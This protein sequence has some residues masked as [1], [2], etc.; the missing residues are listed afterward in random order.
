MTKLQI[1]HVIV[2]ELI[3]ES[4]KDFDHSKPYN[5]RESELDKA[6]S[7]VIQLVNGVVELYGTKGNAAHYG[8]FKSNPMEQGPVPNLFHSYQEIK[9]SLSADFINL[10]K[11]VMKQM[12]KSAQKQTWSS[13]GYVVF[14]D[15]IISNLRYLL[16]T[17][18]KKTNGVTISDNLEPEEMIHLELNNINQAAKINFNFYFSYQQ[19]DDLKKAELSYLSFISKTTGQSAAAYFIEALGCDKGIASA[20]ATRKLPN[21]VKKFFKKNKDLA[22]GAD[23]VR[24]SIIKYLEI[25]FDKHH[26]AKL[27]DIEAIALTHMAFLS[28]T[29]KEKKTRELMKHLNS[30]DIRIPT[31]FVI[32]K[33]SLDKIRNVIF[34]TPQYSFNFDKDLLGVTPDATISYN[35]ANG[36]LT[37]NNLP[38]EA[39]TKIKQALKELGSNNQE[40]NN[41]DDHL[42]E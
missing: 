38:V 11:Q 9:E 25:Q 36:N 6:N 23:N 2:H 26:S 41:S 8:V 42:K 15:Y 28:D 22:T 21:E 35:D 14:T 4:N 10:S 1:N 29:E 7:L 30:E 5:L 17:M 33:T 34:K 40:T 12:Y 18:I 32:N 13:G 27:T 39:R 20:G 19:A 16:V 3:K 24:N 31:E 37:F